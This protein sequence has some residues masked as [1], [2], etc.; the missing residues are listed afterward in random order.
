MRIFFLKK[1]KWRKYHIGKN[2]HC[3]RGVFLWGRDGISIGDDCYIGKYCVIE[4]NCFIGNGVLIANHVGI[5]G[6]YDHNYQ[7]IGTPIRLASQIRDDDYCWKGLNQKTIIE[8]DVWIGFG[9]IILSGVRVSEGCII[10]AG[11]VVSKNTEPYCIYAGVPAKKIGN[12]FESK[13]ELQMHVESI[14]Q[15][16]ATC[17]KRG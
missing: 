5:V 2:F 3:G 11:A 10:A 7:E 4:T 17:N 14:H 15:K 16:Y 13:Q 1:I 8:N 9:A 12:R 6:R